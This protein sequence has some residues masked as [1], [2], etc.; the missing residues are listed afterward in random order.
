MSKGN[1]AKKGTGKKYP[2]YGEMLTAPQIAERYG[3]NAA[4]VKLR[5]ESGLRDEDV[6]KR[7]RKKKYNPNNS[8]YIRHCQLDTWTDT[9]L[10]CYEIGA[11][12]KLCLLPESIK[13][14]C[15]MKEK[16]KEI[17]KIYGKPYDRTAERN[18]YE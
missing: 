1:W 16:I 15:H 3:L 14:Q 12:C 6:L 5:L 17:V 2:F 7:R 11:N 4:T 10:D 9:A 18:F 8:D 13:K